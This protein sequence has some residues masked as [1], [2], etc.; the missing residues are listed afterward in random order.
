MVSIIKVALWE[1]YIPEALI[2]KTMVLIRKGKGEYRG[3]GL[4]E[5][6]WKVCTSI[7]NSRLQSSIVLHD[8]LHG[9]RQGRGTGTV[10]MKAKLE[11]QLAWIFHK[12]LFQVFLDVSKSYDPLDRRICM[13]ILRKYGLGPRLQQLLQRYWDI[14]RVVTN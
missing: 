12:P 13:E 8:V 2:W 7:V 1:G 4:V 5:T 11:Q 3:I 10:I 6:I 9:F 14:H